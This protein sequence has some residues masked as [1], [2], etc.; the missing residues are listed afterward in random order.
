MEIEITERMKEIRVKQHNIIVSIHRSLLG[1][2]GY[3]D[4]HE[5]S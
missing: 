1:L 4:V 2:N 5:C 3:S